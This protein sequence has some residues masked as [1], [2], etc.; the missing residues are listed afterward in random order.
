MSTKK[1]QGPLLYIHQPFSKNP[2][3]NNMQEVFTNKQNQ[4][5][6][7]EEIP[8]EKEARKKLSLVK[9][10]IE[11]GTEVKSEDASIQSVANNKEKLHRA[12]F[13]RVKSFK[14]MDLL[15]RLDYLI[16]FPK[17]LPPVPCVF[18]TTEN[19]YQ[20]YLTE[21]TPQQVTIQSKDNTTRTIP[22]EEL[23][24]IIMIGIKK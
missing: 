22:F 19:N 12:S 21:Y 16:N 20:G 24:N 13:N 5:F 1:S 14:E 17:V 7:K 2:T 11:Q 8:V 4:E 15:E 3:N 9:K 18:Y 6:V 23:K 10:D